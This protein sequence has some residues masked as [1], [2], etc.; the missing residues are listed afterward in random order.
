ML[1]GV[2]GA[3]TVV[4]NYYDGPADQLPENHIVNDNLRKSI[5]DSDLT[6]KDALVILPQ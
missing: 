3:N 1:I 5:V 4:N 6:M 2:H